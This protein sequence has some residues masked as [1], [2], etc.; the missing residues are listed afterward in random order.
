MILRLDIRYSRAPTNVGPTLVWRPRRFVG[1]LAA[2]VLSLLGSQAWGQPE[3]TP[4]VRFRDSI[5]AIPPGSS[6]VTVGQRPARISRATLTAE[7]TAAPMDFELMLAMR[8]FSE[9]SARVARRELISREEMDAKYF[10]LPAD[11]DAIASWLTAQGFTITHEFPTRLS[12]FAQGP[13]NRVA[14]VFQVTFA[15]VAAD[16]DEFTSAITAPS[17]PT[18]LAPALLGIDGLQPHLRAHKF[19][20]PLSAV[21]NSLT[22]NSP[23]YTPAQILTAYGANTTN[24]TGAGETIAI[25]IDTFPANSDLVSFWSQCGIGQS[26][27][28]IQEVQVISG[29][30]TGIDATEATLDA[31]LASGLAPAATVRIYATTDLESQHLSAAFQQILADLPSQ[32][33]LHQLSLSFGSGESESSPGQL[34]HEAQVFASLAAGGVTVFAS[35]GDGGSNP[36]LN[37]NPVSYDPSAPLQPEWPA[38]DPSVTGVGGTTLFLDPSTGAISSESAWS[39]ARTGSGGSGGGVSSVFARPS[40]QTGPGVLA[41]AMRLIPDVSAVGNPNTGCFIVLH[42]SSSKNY[43]GTSVSAP[44]W[45]SLCAMLNQGRAATGQQ[46][47]GLL[48]PSIY[49]LIGTTA[50]RDITGGTN[51]AYTAGFGYDLVTGVGTP[52]FG[53]LAQAFDAVAFPPAITVQPVS[54]TVSPRQNATFS[55]TANGNP[56]PV[57]QWQRE[58]MGSSTWTN[59]NDTATYTGSGTASLTVNSVT[60]AMSGDSFNCVV[61]N[62]VGSALTLPAVLVVANPL[63]VT[64]LAGLASSSGSAGGTGSAARFNDPADLAA[65]RS[66]NV[67]VAD[68]NN[69]TIRRITPVG[70]VTTMAGQAGVSG[71]TDGTASVAQFNHPTGVSVDAPGNLYVADTD[72]DT[73]R[74][75]TPAGGVTTIAGLAGRTGSADG[76][77]SAALF[78]SPSD[79]AVD[80]AGNLYVSDTLNHTIRMIT[81]AGAVTTIAGLAGASGSADGAGSAARFFA[82]EGIAVDGSGNLYVADT[83][84]HTIRKITA[85]GVVSTLAGWA[86]SSGSSDGIGS[87]ARFFY[88]AD[89]TIDGTGNLFVIDTDNHTIRQITSVGVVSTVA[90]QAGTSGNADGTGTSARFNYPTG[91]GADAS[92]NLFVADTNNQTIRE[93]VPQSAPVIQTQPQSQTVTAGANVSFSVAATGTPAPSYQWSFNGAAIFGATSPGLMLQSVQTSNAGYYT[94]TVYNSLGVVAS[95][96]AT[97]TVNAVVSQPSSSGTSGGGGGGGAP[98]LWFFGLLTLTY[99]LRRRA[100]MLRGLLFAG[101]GR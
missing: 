63:V 43:G 76:T 69:H 9:L 15:R 19:T 93:A 55:V 59:L 1:L 38:D 48:G 72:N 79:V 100:L 84:N 42:G 31:E 11:Y 12:V 95:N 60:A 50:L 51:G 24:L 98:S 22:S 14:D 54:E 34:N 23:P 56:P 7:E 18:A 47:L 8:N 53:Q 97:L 25:V 70:A 44:I 5:V 6:A 67:Y 32:P 86:G 4:R 88:P 49:P 29:S 66:G 62:S 57:F 71:S 68:A 13:V 41:G 89:V 52:V 30:L 58:P 77:G 39:V 96:P 80:S 37:S 82:P 10:P 92:G 40:W 91:I 27:A 99:G 85:T 87:G 45:A 61:T 101:K 28:N 73:I 21:P 46:P 75:V 35:T 90:G 3:R 16:G 2:I 17:L 36:N 83:D 26:I 81:P 20:A 64:T 78:S 33:G 94:V 74:K 65:D